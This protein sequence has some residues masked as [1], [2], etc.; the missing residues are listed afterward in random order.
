M[1]DSTVPKADTPAPANNAKTLLLNSNSRE[2]YAR[3]TAGGNAMGGTPEGGSSP[4]GGPIPG[5]AVNWSGADGGTGSTQVA[6][7][8]FQG[9]TLVVPQ[10]DATGHP[11]GDAN[12]GTVGDSGPQQVGPGPTPN[13]PS[14]MPDLDHDGDSL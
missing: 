12:G 10:P 7:E 5:Y 4:A 8:V 9:S 2:L 13:S 11:A 14:G 6:G 3:P 1:A